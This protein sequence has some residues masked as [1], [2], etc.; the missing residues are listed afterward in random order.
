MILYFLKD[1]KSKIS[2]LH[3]FQFTA[4]WE[5]LLSLFAEEIEK[6]RVWRLFVSQEVLTEE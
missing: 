6:F 5:G 1:G 4:N 3:M 2:A